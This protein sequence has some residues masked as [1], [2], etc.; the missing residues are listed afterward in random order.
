[1]KR[2]A[3]VAA[4]GMLTAS[5]INL[6]G[7]LFATKKFEIVLQSSRVVAS[8]YDGYFANLSGPSGPYLAVVFWSDQNLQDMAADRRLAMQFRAWRCAGG[9]AQSSQRLITDPILYDGKGKVVD[10]ES[11]PGEGPYHGYV[12]LKWTGADVPPYD[13][14][15]AP[16]DVCV[17]ATGA[18]GLEV[19]SLFSYQVTSNTL[20]IPAAELAREI[21]D[22]RQRRNRK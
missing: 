13:L 10:L 18:T 15:R 22:L 2:V 14:V 5:C 19:A 8:K 17:K 9:N 11:Q 12:Q 16:E 4:L 1:M 7:A 6:Y 3:F 20:V 21:A